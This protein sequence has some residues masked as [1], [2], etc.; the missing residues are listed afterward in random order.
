MFLGRLLIVATPYVDLRC[1]IWDLWYEA[2]W[3]LITLHK[4][5]QKASLLK[6]IRKRV[7]YPWSSLP[8]G[9]PFYFHSVPLSEIPVFSL[10]PSPLFFFSMGEEYRENTGIFVYTGRTE[11]DIDT[12]FI[13]YSFR[14]AP[15]LIHM[16]T[17]TMCAMTHSY[18]HRD[19]GF[20]CAL[21]LCVPWLIHVC[22]MWRDSYHTHTHTHTHTGGTRKAAATSVP[23][24]LL[25]PPLGRCWHPSDGLIRDLFISVCHSCVRTWLMFCLVRDSFIS[26]TCS[27]VRTCLVFSLPLGRCWHPSGGL[28]GGSHIY[29]NSFVCAN[30]THVLSRSWIIHKCGSFMCMTWLMFDSSLVRD[31]FLR[32]ICWRYCH[33]STVSFVTHSTLLSFVTHFWEWHAGD[34][35]I[36]LTVSFVTHS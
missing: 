21:W 17:V 13:A 26:V 18:V 5:H 27:C 32:V 15:W 23:V 9:Y 7:C 30:M 35:A 8:A 36:P 4:T 6:H 20:I 14:C 22:A 19:S 3:N 25:N 10:H 31:S 12:E 29:V 11:W 16:C 28:V 2:I 34:T 1:N 24:S 33:P